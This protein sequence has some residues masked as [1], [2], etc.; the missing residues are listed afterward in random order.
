M[1]L[2]EYRTLCGEI[3][4]G[5]LGRGTQ[6]CEGGAATAE[7]SV[8]SNRVTTRRGARVPGNES[9]STGARSSESAIREI[10]L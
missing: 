3:P 6:G 2:K 7:G 5:T 8:E 9:Y 10:A 1:G 4:A